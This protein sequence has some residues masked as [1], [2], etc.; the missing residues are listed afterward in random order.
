[1]HFLENG[2]LSGESFFICWL[3]L[4]TIVHQGESMGVGT[5][6]AAAA[7]IFLPIIKIGI[8]R[9]S[10]MKKKKKDEKFVFSC[11]GFAKFT[12]VIFANRDNCPLGIKDK[13]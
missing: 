13:R 2:V 9:K 7:P 5:G 10:K 6:A 8:Y 11:N 4:E 1:M 3:L 12:G